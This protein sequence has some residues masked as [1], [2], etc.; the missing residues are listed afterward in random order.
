MPH[1]EPC[2][3]YS[4]VSEFRM[5]R[6]VDG[7]ECVVDVWTHKWVHESMITMSVISFSMT[8]D[9]LNEHRFQSVHELGL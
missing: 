1:T 4:S 6:R 5:K 3:K 8:S 7:Y 9:N 2:V